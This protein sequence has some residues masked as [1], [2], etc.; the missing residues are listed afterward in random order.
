MTGDNGNRLPALDEVIEEVLDGALAENAEASF[1]RDRLLAAIALISGAGLFLGMPF[2][3]RM[4]A[5]FFL[6]VTAA[7][8]VAIALVPL[9]EWLERRR[10]PSSLAAFTCLAFFLTIANIA[11]ALIVVP[12]SD[13]FARLPERAGQI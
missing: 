2:A 12:A 8:V 4:G 5:E 10:V 6:P 3:L 13:W 9:L 7:L 11:V 1:R